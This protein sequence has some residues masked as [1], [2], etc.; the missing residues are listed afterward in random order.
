MCTIE[1]NTGT[2]PA[3]ATTPQT[4][5]AVFFSCLPSDSTGTVAGNRYYR[6]NRHYRGTSS[7]VE[8]LYRCEGFWVEILPLLVV[9][10]F[11]KGCH[12][13]YSG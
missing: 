12:R 6:G 4:A 9:L 13:R 5:S 7:V 11:A 2:I 10:I 8:A 3:I 1:G